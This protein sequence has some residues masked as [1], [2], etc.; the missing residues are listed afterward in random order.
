[1]I[2]F[3]MAKQDLYRRVYQIVLQIPAGRVAT[4]GQIARLAGMAGHARQVGYALHNLPDN[5]NVPWQ[6]V[7]NAR[8]QISFPPESLQRHIQQTI[9]VSE[10]IRFDGNDT[11]SLKWYQWKPDI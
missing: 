7:I 5:S 6:R 9:L 3:S 8:G 2:S 1:M 4:Y 10:G 11:V